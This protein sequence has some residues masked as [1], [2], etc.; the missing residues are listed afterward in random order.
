MSTEREGAAESMDTEDDGVNQTRTAI[1]LARCVYC[2]K[3]FLADAGQILLT[4]ILQHVQRTYPRDEPPYRCPV[5]RRCN[6]WKETKD[7]LAGHIFGR[8]TVPTTT[9]HG[10]PDHHTAIHNS[11]SAKEDLI[12][13]IARSTN[14]PPRLADHI[15]QY[16]DNR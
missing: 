9:N 11:S 5:A 13:R 6:K 10:T 16:V 15:R 12:I 14:G 1:T 4:H 3:H 2:E 8:H 7:K